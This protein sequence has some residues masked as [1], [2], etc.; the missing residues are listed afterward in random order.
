MMT[1]L[2]RLILRRNYTGV[3]SVVQVW[4]NAGFTFLH[5]ELILVNLLFLLL[6]SVFLD[7]LVIWFQFGLLNT[8]LMLFFFEF[9]WHDRASSLLLH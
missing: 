9:G 6:D 2:A 5:L 1:S 3:T 8:E 7:H 4:I